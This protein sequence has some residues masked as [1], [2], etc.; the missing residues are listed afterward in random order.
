MRKTRFIPPK[1]RKEPFIIK[2]VETREPFEFPIH[3][4]EQI[5]PGIIEKSVRMLGILSKDDVHLV[6]P[7][8]SQ[9]Y[10]KVWAEGNFVPKQLIAPISKVKRIRSNVKGAQFG[11]RRSRKP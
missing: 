9:R 1:A 8:R 6:N 2:D 4:A 3:K 5:H 10:H 11:A 7:Y